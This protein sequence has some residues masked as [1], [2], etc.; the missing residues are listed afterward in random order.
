[1]A[2]VELYFLIIS[3]APYFSSKVVTIA[4]YQPCVFFFGLSAP[5]AVAVKEEEVAAAG[6]GRSISTLDSGVNS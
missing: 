3:M 6:K 1:M 2:E 4:E 5:Q